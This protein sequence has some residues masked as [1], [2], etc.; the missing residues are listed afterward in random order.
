MKKTS[1]AKRHWLRLSAFRAV[2]NEPG[3]SEE[4]DRKDQTRASA[5]V[6]SERRNSLRGMRR[7]VLLQANPFLTS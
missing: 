3:E 1:I 7:R 5:L 6:C 2:E 4:E